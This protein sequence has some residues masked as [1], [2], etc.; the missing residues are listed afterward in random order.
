VSALLFFEHELH[1]L[2]ELYENVSNNRCRADVDSV[3]RNHEDENDR[4]Y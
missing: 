1:E 4:E 2:N 3:Q